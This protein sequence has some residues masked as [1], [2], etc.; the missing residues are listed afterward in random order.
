MKIPHWRILLPIGIALSVILLVVL[1][2]VWPGSHSETPQQTDPTEPAPS[3]P[4]FG[5]RGEGNFRYYL[6][7]DGTR[8]IGWL[9]EDGA[10]YFFKN[11]SFL[12]TGWLT[13]DDATY[14][15]MENGKMATGKHV[16]DG[17]NYYFTADG[18]SFLLVNP[19]SPVPEGYQPTLNP[20]PSTYADRNMQ[21]DQACYDALI[22][23][24]SDAHLSGEFTLRVIS[25]YRTQEMQ[26]ENFNKKLSSL[27]AQGLSYEEAYEKTCTIIAVPGTSEHQIGL[28]VDIIDMRLL[29]LTEEQADTPGQQWL[30]EHCWEYG[31]VLRYPKD[32]TNETGIIYEPWHYRYVGTELAQILRDN[33][34][35]LEAYMDSIS[36]AETIDN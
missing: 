8:H 24:L 11:N 23:M 2:L 30:M 5:W 9:E 13:L 29:D 27:M 21:V 31:F 19:W 17:N 14:Y 16:I 33:G 10:K 25:A 36:N 34:L 35:T 22:S 18:K 20:I 1:I 6:L 28:A 7:E 12:H 26:E 3:T 4:A 32:K 15:F